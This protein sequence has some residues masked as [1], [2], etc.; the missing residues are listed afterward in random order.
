MKKI[1]LIL[2]FLWV[3]LI[4]GSSFAA[5]SGDELIR[6][7]LNYDNKNAARVSVTSDDALAL[8]TVIDRAPVQI[9]ECDAKSASFE[10]G[11]TGD[12]NVILDKRYDT[13]SE[14]YAD[15]GALRQK[16]STAFYYYNNGWYLVLG[17][18]D[19]SNQAK[20]KLSSFSAV[21]SSDLSI[22]ESTDDDVS[23]Q[24]GGKT[25]M[26]YSS[27]SSDFFVASVN[28]PNSGLVAYGDKVYRGGIGT[29][30]TALND[31]AVINYLV[32]DHYLYGVLPKE[33]SESWPK[34][35]LK[36][37]AVVA[38]NFAIANFDKHGEEGY[39]LCSTTN[40]QVY[41]GYG[42]EKPSS[43]LA[44]DESSR[45]LLYYNDE[46]VVGYYHAN[47]GGKTADIES[48]WSA[49]VPYLQSVEDPYSLDAPNADWTVELSPKAIEQQLAD[50][51]YFIGTLK[52]IK[53]CDVAD[54]GRVQVIDFIGDKGT[55]TLKKEEMRKV[56]GYVAF[57]SIYFDLISGDVLSVANTTQYSD[58]TLADAKV[59]NGETTTPLS[60][61]NSVTIIGMEGRTTVDMTPSNY[62]FVGH[63]FGHG[64]GMSQWGAKKMAEEGFDYEGILYHYYTGTQLINN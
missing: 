61:K 64:I 32:M 41:G 28:Y 8:F 42:V 17:R 6:V 9:F 5:Y 25:V 55:A 31:M 36:A 35:A 62:T 20:N 12:L 51:N 38:R 60:S 13:F 39:D 22:R 11:A 40:C 23:I 54:D 26:A 29:N 46:L 2:A 33:M 18:Y 1:G 58:V 63:G 15:A 21:S 50:Q 52:G 49:E 59:F 24:V 37:Q 48:V 45:D 4:S 3:I 16:Y 57:K 44:V 30:R 19:S 43:N 14:L 47:S 10:K 53:I 34:E 7:G 56:F 27:A